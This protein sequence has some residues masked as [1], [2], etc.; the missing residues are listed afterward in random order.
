M[1]RAFGHEALAPLA[2]LVMML[3][4]Y[5]RYYEQFPIFEGTGGE[6]PNPHHLGPQEPEETTT[7]LAGRG[8]GVDFQRMRGS[9]HQ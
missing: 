7:S 2:H 8:K 3:L 9:L 5:A 6:D 1:E 4:L